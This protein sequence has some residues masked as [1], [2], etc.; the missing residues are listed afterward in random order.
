MKKLEQV[1]LLCI[2]SIV[3]NACGNK[4]NQ[5]PVNLKANTDIEI[6]YAEEGGVK[7]IPVKL[8]GR[9]MDMVFDTGCSGMSISLLEVQT[10]YKSRKISERDILGTTY[11]QIADGSIVE[12]ALI[13]L[14]E[15]EIGGKNGIVLHNVKASVVL[16][17][18]APLLLGNAVL[19]EVKSVEVDNNKKTIKFKR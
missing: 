1:L 7:M 4:N 2:M 8:N 15:V 3:I 9:E 18:E 17:Q 6:A 13:N 5:P 19:D 12:N 10:L 16:N 14:R 11:A